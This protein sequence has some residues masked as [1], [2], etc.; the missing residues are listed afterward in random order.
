MSTKTLLGLTQA[1]NLANQ[2][3]LLGAKA[4]KSPQIFEMLTEQM[5]HHRCKED[6][7]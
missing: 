7:E 3:R 6:Y 5:K 1:L 2:I 4:P